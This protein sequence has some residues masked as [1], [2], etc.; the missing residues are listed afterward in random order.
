MATANAIP[1]RLE[2]GGLVS[3][4]DSATTLDFQIV[5]T[6][7]VV[8]KSGWY[9]RI[10]YRN[11]GAMQPPREGDPQESEIDL[12]LYYTGALQ[13]TDVQKFLEVQGTNG[14]AKEFTITIKRAAYAGA[15]SGEIRTWTQCSLEGG[16]E[17][18]GA[19]PCDTLKA[20]FKSRNV[21]PA[22]TAYP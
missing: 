10:P 1:L 12:A 15:T 19:V 21:K 11:Y 13:A 16:C 7:E 8:E 18:K 22:V 17:V 20:K 14:L 6:S 2:A 9:E 4:N 3:V 5:L